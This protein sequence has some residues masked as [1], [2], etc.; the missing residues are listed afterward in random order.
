MK[1]T[2][3]MIRILNRLSISIV[4]VSLML[5]YATSVSAET[6]GFKPLMFKKGE[7][8]LDSGLRYETQSAIPDLLT[9]ATVIKNR[10][11]L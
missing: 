10:G 3:E 7:V 8:Q 9:Q 6:N 1:G 2:D 5:F 11:S 4:I